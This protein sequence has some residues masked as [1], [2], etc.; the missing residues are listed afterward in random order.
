MECVNLR[1]LQPMTTLAF[2][3][4]AA[5]YYAQGYWRA[6]DLWTDF[7][8]VV[9][10]DPG[11]H[12]LRIGERSVTYGELAR[13]AASLSARLAADGVERGD[14]VILLGRNSLAAAI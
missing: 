11:K 4:D 1:S 10:T 3:P 9:A 6:S 5:D 2:Q 8:S 14:V 12:A 13:A 7:T